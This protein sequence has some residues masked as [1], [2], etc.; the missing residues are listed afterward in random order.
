[1]GEAEIPIVDDADDAHIF[2]FE[3]FFNTH[4]AL[5]LGVYLRPRPTIISAPVGFV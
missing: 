3:T 4:D 1:L 5:T 2:S